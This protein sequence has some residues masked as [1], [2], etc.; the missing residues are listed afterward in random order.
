M[1]KKLLPVLLLILFASHLSLHAQQVGADSL[2]QP[3]LLLALQQPDTS[4]L[5]GEIKHNL[6]PLVKK[7]IAPSVLIGLGIVHM[8]DEGLFEGSRGLRSAVQNRFEGFATG[9]DDHAGS[10]P[11]IA[12]VGLNLAGVE[13]EHHYTEQAILLGMTYYLNRTLTNN[14]KGLTRI[15]RPG[16]GTA[17][18]FPSGHTS[19]AFAYATFF[20]KEYGKR[21]IWYSVMGYSFATATGAIRI[22][23]DRH[24]L[25]DVL[26]GAGIGILSAEVVYYAY[27]LFKQKLRQYHITRKNVGVL[28]FYSQGAGGL[29]LVIPLP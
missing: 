13:G 22:L 9:V 7:S 21:G 15:K 24:W 19:T 10:F 2:A 1:M 5:S 14:L 29:A 12:T 3:N 16:D 25:S 6:H 26:A 20:H 17:D 11:L 8:D 18:A 28:P 4:T 23:N 27:P